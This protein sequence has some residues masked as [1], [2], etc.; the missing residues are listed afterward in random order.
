M[1]IKRSR[2]ACC[3]LYVRVALFSI[4]ALCRSRGAIHR[5]AFITFLIWG[6]L[7]SYPVYAN[8]SEALTAAYVYYFTK[9]VRLDDGS[10]LN[11]VCVISQNNRLTAEFKKVAKK[12][13]GLITISF[14]PL[15]NASDRIL[16]SGCHILYAVYDTEYSPALLSDSSHLLVLDEGM[17]SQYAVIQ[18]VMDGNR[19]SFEIDRANAQRKEL[20]IS[21]KLLKLAKRVKK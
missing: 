12:S 9:F 2:T 19:L 6:C 7:L 10:N 4:L 16:S 15:Q 18:L 8:R 21:G 20:S 13:N 11:H 17:D 14:F 1:R 5:Y 3:Y